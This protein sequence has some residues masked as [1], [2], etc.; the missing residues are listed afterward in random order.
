MI[1]YLN[2]IIAPPSGADPAGVLIIKIDG[3]FSMT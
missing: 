2:C 1:T 3:N